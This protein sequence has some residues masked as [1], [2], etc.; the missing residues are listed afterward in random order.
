[1]STRPPQSLLPGAGPVEARLPLGQSGPAVL[2]SFA[3]RIAARRPALA[4]SLAL[5]F[6]FK[7]IV[8]LAVILF[9]ISA[10]EPVAMIAVAGTIAVLGACV[11]WLLARRIPI[12][13]FELLAAA[14]SIVTSVLVAQATTHGGMMIAAFS[15]PWIA[16]YSAHFF[17]RRVVIMQGILISIGF[18]V[19]LLVGGLPD[20]AIYWVVVTVTIWSICIVLG[21]L[22]ESLRRQAD[23]DPL[24]G[25]L[26]RN[27]FMA[28]AIRE[29]AIAQRSG[30]RLTLALL[31]L[32]GFKQV[33]DQRGHVAG[34]G[35][36]AELGRAWRERLRTGDIL[37]RHGG[38]EFVLLLPATAP[39]G[40]T[41]VLDRLRVE[42]LPVTWSVG[43]GEWLAGESL[44]ECL[45]RADTHL[46]SVKN[47]LRVRDA[48][49]HALRS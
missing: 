33:N 34:D 21:E 23:T 5:L 12:V 49:A 2:R 10:V 6:L 45:A 22:S 38:D 35:V 24:T 32:D 19:G 42:D 39:E 11:V 47:T 48:R 31:D 43:I 4:W 36:L 18:G 37:A 16:I 25:L 17:P 1:M 29:H 28:A 20:V 46:Y 44:G 13:G 30:N 27:G 15:Y 40:A 3:R 14:G 7:G 8:C 9:P 41:A 26:N